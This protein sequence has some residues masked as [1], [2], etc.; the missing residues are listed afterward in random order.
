MSQYVFSHVYLDHKSLPA[1][2]SS[3]QGS[4]EMP[5]QLS[6]MQA[7]VYFLH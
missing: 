1:M 3:A 7:L 6:G 5:A 2:L 4:V